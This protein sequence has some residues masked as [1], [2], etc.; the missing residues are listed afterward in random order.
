MRK[1]L[2][3][4]LWLCL[5]SLQLL[6]QTKTI[7]GKVV[8]SRNG[9]PLGGVS[10][11]ARGAAGG[12]QT[13]PDGSFT[14]TVPASVR[15]ISLSFTGFVTKDINVVNSNIVN[16][17]LDIDDRN[18]DEVVVTGYTRENKSKYAG[19]SSKIAA[20]KINQVPMGSFDQILQGRTPGLFVGSGSGQPGA[21]AT[22]L[23]RGA[24]SINGVTNPLYIMDGIPIEPAVFQSMNAS[25]F[26]SVDVLKD[27]IASALYGSRGANGVIVI[28]TKKGKAGRTVFSVKTQAGFA[29]RTDRKFSMMDSRQRIQFEEEIGKEYG[30]T[31]GPGWYLSRDNPD[32]A[33]L[34]AAELAQYDLWLDSLR[35]SNVDWTD[36]FFRTGQ[37]QEHEVSASGGSDKVRFYSSVNYFKQKGIALRSDLERFTFRTNLDF[38]SSRLNTSL[39]MSVGYSKRNFIE[40]EQATSILNPF[41]SVYYALPYEQPYINGKLIPSSQVGSVGGVFDQRE[42]TDALERATNSTFR[43][44]QLKGTLSANLNFKISRAVSAIGTVGIDFRETINDRLFKPGTQTG[45]SQIGGRGRYDQGY[46]RNVQVIGNGGFNFNQLFA[47]RHQV[48]ASVLA[49]AIRDWGNSFNYSGF[50]IDPLRQGS[51]SAITP[52]SPTNGLIPLVGGTLDNPNRAYVGFIG[53]AKYTFDNKYTLNASFRRDGSTQAPEVNRWKNYYAFGFIWNVMQERF[54]QDVSFLNALNFRASHGQSAAQFANDFAYLANYTGTNNQYDGVQGSAPTFGDPNYDWEYTTTSNIGID[55]NFWEN[56]A[57]AK[58]DVYNR[59]TTNLVINQGLSRTSGFAQ[60]LVNAGEMYNRGIEVDLSVDVIKRRNILWSLTGNFAY[61]KNKVTSLG[62][63]NEFILGTS[64]VRVGLPLGSHYVVKW[65]GVDPQTGNPQYYK[66]DGTI[67]ST[68]P[69]SEQVA[70]FG[71]SNPPYVG[72]FGTTLRVGDFT[73]DAFFSYMFGFKRFNNED[74]FNENITF[75]TSNQ[76]ERVFTDRWR[77]PGDITDI[78]RY[79]AARQFSSKDIQ[80]SSFLRFRNVNIN[81]N[82]PRKLLGKT[83]FISNA[84]IYVQAQ[85]LFTWT[86]WRGFDPEDGNNISRFDYPANRVFTGGVKI[87]F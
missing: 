72:G 67:T 36:I 73:F 14:I 37:F 11:I 20:A 62:S 68:F 29:T 31:I 38:S 84:V 61:N 86:S 77:K 1:S 85:N 58:L 80:N 4:M 6:A 18:L 21:A 32:N 76:S 23:I 45:N 69:S 52:G 28:T 27:A 78:Q 51:P 15:S 70:E 46:T 53:S 24:G 49:E 59:N 42:G 5:I 2:L 22:V 64:I 41:A 33:S 74:F 44:N 81:Y 57:R 63:A 55:V 10:V 8:D 65:A 75:A 40:Q 34:P 60:G 35:N 79:S 66:K 82:I 39:N 71:T 47:E 12:T 56:R 16:V 87:D 25:D 83:G 7:S 19:A 13:Q 3:A 54:M 9:Q 30:A 17:S 26:E 43:N 48:S 50:G